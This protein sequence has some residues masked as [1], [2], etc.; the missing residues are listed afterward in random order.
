MCQLRFKIRAYWQ[1]VIE[2][3]DSK[4]TA[5]GAYTACFKTLHTSKVGRLGFRQEIHNVYHL[6]V[7]HQ[8]AACYLLL[9]YIV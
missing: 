7:R 3:C 4:L 6:A 9:R 1:I 8:G 5:R 2:L